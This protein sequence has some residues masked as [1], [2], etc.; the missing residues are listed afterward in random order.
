MV[1]TGGRLTAP[2]H[3]STFTNVT[4][5]PTHP[6][7]R[8]QPQPAY[9]LS[10][11]LAALDLTLLTGYVKATDLVF[12]GQLLPYETADG[13]TGLTGGGFLDVQ[14]LM[15]AANAVLS[16]T[17]PGAPSAE[18]NQTYETAL[19]QVLQ[20]ANGNTDFVSQELLWGLV[21]VY[22]SL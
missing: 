9:R 17:K 2:V 21:S 19:A 15:S 18:P 11:Q 20:A 12:S 10:V 16:R 14:D 22:P 1:V 3:N 13:I 7:H 8:R 5:A 6:D 4:D